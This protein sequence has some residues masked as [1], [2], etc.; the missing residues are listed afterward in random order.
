LV[1]PP[2]FAFGGMENPCMTFVSPTVVTG[3]KGNTETIAHELA[4]SW[5]GNLVTNV[6]KKHFW[7]NEGFTV[8]IEG[9]ILGRIHGEASRDLNGIGHLRKLQKDVDTMFNKTSLVGAGAEDAYS[10]V[11]YGKGMAFARYLEETV[12]G[13]P[14]FE[15]FLKAYFNHFANQSIETK[16]FQDYFLRYFSQNRA[17]RGIDWDTW[18]YKPGMPVV[19]PKFDYSLVEECREL[20]RYWQGTGVRDMDQGRLKT[21]F[22]KLSTPQ[23]QEFLEILR[24]GEALGVEKIKHMSDLYALDSSPNAEILMRW[25]RL[26]IKARYKP[27]ATQA[28]RRIGN[29]GRYRIIEPLYIDLYNW[30]DTRQAALNTFSQHKPGLMDNAIRYLSEKLY[31]KENFRSFSASESELPFES[32][33]PFESGAVIERNPLQNG[34]VHW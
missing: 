18:L 25:W 34:Q 28:L 3:D 5:A 2:A 31:P 32:E 19:M 1:L 24:E 6:N 30:E 13:P 11:A 14:I 22:N 12:G 27:I 10:T 7:L 16:D 8:F 9:K 23:K 17:V 26:G 21:M 4:H 20:A 29:Y 15:K 33:S